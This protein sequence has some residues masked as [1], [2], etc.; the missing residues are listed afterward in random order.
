MGSPSRCAI[1]VLPINYLFIS[2]GR[3]RILRGGR[4]G[5]GAISPMRAIVFDFGYILKGAYF[6]YFLICVLLN[7]IYFFRFSFFENGF[8]ISFLRS[9]LGAQSLFAVV[10]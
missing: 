9:V 1:Y 2:A 7:Y 5:G 10:F 6:A 8:S 3:A 4:V